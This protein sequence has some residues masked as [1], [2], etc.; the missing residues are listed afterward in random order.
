MLIV[1]C[2]VGDIPLQQIEGVCCGTILPFTGEILH[3]G[4]TGLT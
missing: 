3:L 4:F 1:A 2:T